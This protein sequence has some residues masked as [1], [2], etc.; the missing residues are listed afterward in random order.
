MSMKLVET[1]GPNERI[2]SMI[3]F[4]DMVLVATEKSVYRLIKDEFHVIKFVLEEEEI[5]DG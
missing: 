2:V 4:K 1:L 3:E 5:N